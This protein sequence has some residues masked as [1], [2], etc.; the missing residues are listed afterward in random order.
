MK[1]VTLSDEQ[2]QEI[3]DAAQ[4]HRDCGPD[5]EGWQSEELKR[6]VAALEIALADG[7]TTPT[8]RE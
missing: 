2:W 5:G 6:A 3:L 8:R 4:Q 7:E 1:T